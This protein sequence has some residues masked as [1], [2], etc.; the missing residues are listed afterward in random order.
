MK[1]VVER[2]TK[3]FDIFRELNEKKVRYWKEFPFVNNF[4]FSACYTERRS[5]TEKNCCERQ[6]NYKC[7]VF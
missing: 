2:R 7:T 4:R 6:T 5:V 1:S 3:K